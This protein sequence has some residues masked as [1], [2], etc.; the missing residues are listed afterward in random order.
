MI[1]FKLTLWSKCALFGT[2]SFG[3]RTLILLKISNTFKVVINESLFFV[4]F[5]NTLS[6]GNSSQYYL[7]IESLQK[8]ISISDLTS[9]LSDFEKI[10]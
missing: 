6:L 2:I 9:S 4:C 7:S 3:F 1:N 10:K 8:I 5:W